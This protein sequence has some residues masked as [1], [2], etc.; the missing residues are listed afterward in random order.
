[1]LGRVATSLDPHRVQRIAL[2]L[3]LAAF[4]AVTI[5]LI[6]VATRGGTTTDASRLTLGERQV[7]ADDLQRV[8]EHATF[9]PNGFVVT[10]AEL[11]TRLG[12]GSGDRVIDMSGTPIS[13]GFALFEILQ[14]ARRR[15]ATALYVTIEAHDARR[16]M[17]WTLDHP[18]T[19]VANIDIT[20]P[21]PPAYTP[22]VTYPPVPPSI[23]PDDALADELRKI[24]HS[25]DTHYTIPRSLVDKVLSNPM[26]V[27]KGARVVPAMKDG[28]PSGFKLYAV[29]P[30]SVFALIGFANGDRIIAVNGMELSSPDKALEMY[31]KLRDATDFAVDIE[32]RGQPMT[33]TIKIR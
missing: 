5:A 23:D 29:R 21:S 17:R 20:P 30:S 13:D 9:G 16:T 31:T 11:A 7:S 22:P 28:K 8:R 2:G 12:L 18:L 14:F 6:V 1:M 32:R 4:V 27:V 24:E 15:A 33:I 19:H 10:D 25:D 26:A 3:A